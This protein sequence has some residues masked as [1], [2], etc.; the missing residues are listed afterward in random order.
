VR[1]ST[2]KKEIAVRLALGASRWRLVRQ[3]LTESVLLATASGV[4][5]LLFAMWIKDGLLAVTGWAGH[6]MAGLDPRLD[7]R[8]L[9]F[10]MVVSLLTG[11]V[12]GLIPAL[13]GTR[14][15][16]TPAL[17]DSGRSSSGASRSWLTRSLVVVQV[18]VSL[19]LLIGAGLLVRTLINLQDIDTGFNENNLL[20]F[21]VEPS[22][23]GY[24][25][26]R[27]AS[28][29][30]RMS[31][32][33]EAVPGVTATTFSELPLLSFM[34]SNS[35]IFLPGAKAGPDG[36]FV[37]SG[38]VY[39]QEVRENFL[40]TM[41]IPLLAGRSLS[42]GDGAGAPKVAVINQTFA[43]RFFPNQNPIG[44]RFG[45]DHTK[46]EEFEIIG[47]A[48]DAKYTSQRD[49]TPSTAYLCWLQDLPSVGAVTFEVRT[50]G[51]PN[52]AVTVIR[53]A[54]REVDS[55]L[56]L[57]DVKTQVEQASET[58]AMERLFAKL[59]T[60]FG[61]LAQQLAAIGL[62]G[63]LAW[64]VSQRT[65]EIGI[66]MAL[67]AD[68]G[69]VLRMIMKQGLALIGVGVSLGLGGAYVLAKYL[70]S[71]TTMLYGV[72]PRDLLTFVVAAVLL[73]FVALLACYFPARRATK[74]DP[75]EA[76]RWE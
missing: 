63:I 20:L 52:A 55:N 73:T 27:L 24:K 29:Y 60:L 32:R 76:L 16:L 69:E 37:P 61:L 34:S 25:G 28:L 58:L 75:L 70:D 18:S 9:A 14:L 62:Y 19:L 53:H 43:T 33:I 40:T 44:K 46:P 67:G 1:A 47:L 41:Q 50:T 45:F 68:R 64:S 8:V 10:T 42:P 36:R 71:L 21:S 72:E 38:E 31:E 56:P 13:R 39:I 30:Q 51:D 48:K 57:K 59:L 3:L 65:Q 17:K 35:S 6:E 7:R 11:I 4:V 26:D 23:L 5:G 2:R 22:L 74:V 12:F 15:D 49:E 66:R 54:V